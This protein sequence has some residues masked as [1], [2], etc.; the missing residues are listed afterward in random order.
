MYFLVL[1]HI[2]SI[3]QSTVALGHFK[4][5][6]NLV[7][8]LVKL[9]EM[10]LFVFL[11]LSILGLNILY[12]L[13]VPSSSTSYYGIVVVPAISSIPMLSPVLQVTY[14]N[15]SGNEATCFGECLTSTGI[16]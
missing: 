7:Y 12:M 8:L 4:M 11:V 9:I 3:F 13:S 15:W 2:P 10:I 1:L 6:C 16:H 5:C 14:R